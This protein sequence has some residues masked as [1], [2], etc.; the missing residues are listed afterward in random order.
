MQK[1][2]TILISAL[3]LALSMIA[4]GNDAD[5][6]TVTEAAVSE[7]AAVTETADNSP[8]PAIPE[9]LN[10]G[11]EEFNI[12]TGTFD[13]YCNMTREESVG[14]VLNDA[15]YN[16]IINTENRLNVDI[17]EYADL[18]AGAAYSQIQKLAAAGDNTYD[19]VNQ[20]VRFN[21]FLLTGGYLQPFTDAPYIDLTAPW[22]NPKINEQL[23]VGGINWFAS[24]ASNVELY[25]GTSCIFIN[26][27]LA[28]QF[29]I[30]VEEIYTAVREGRWTQDMMMQ[31]AALATADLNGD[32]KMT[33]DDRFGIIARDDNIFPM[34]MIVGG[35]EQA[36]IRDKDGNFIPN[37]GTEKYMELAENAYNIF[38]SDDFSSLNDRYI[39]TE[40]ANGRALFMHS[41]FSGV[42]SLS[43]MEDDYTLVPTP[44][45][46]ASQED[47]LCCSYD[48]MMAYALPKSVSDLELSGAVLEWVSYEG[49]LHVED[50]YIETTMKFKKAREETTAEM[51]QICLDGAMIDLGSI[52][53]Y[54]Q[55]SYDAITP[56]MR[57][58]TFKFASFIKGKEKQ[59]N[60]EL[61]LI[62]EAVEKSLEH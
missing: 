26:S 57:G 34:A 45:Y 51:V 55:C 5:S 61:E 20:L 58:S 60:K 41:I 32:G 38:H 54:N 4:C 28:S 31:Y 49:K 14:E 13:Q 25:T 48:C 1:H 2:H 37:W 19:A 39:T 12:I 23:T 33:E 44:K 11:G 42:D 40:F 17:I 50:A 6:N 9:E 62:A 56:I 16:M 7:T 22:W 30:S 29:D 24:S 59:L 21:V 46:D 52:F 10:F 15:I 27:T 18:D 47:Y 43:N 8:K 53:A 36:L 35:G 3:F